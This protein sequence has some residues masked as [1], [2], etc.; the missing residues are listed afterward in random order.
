MLIKLKIK[1]SWLF[2]NLV[3]F[4]SSLP[5][6]F[7]MFHLSFLTLIKIIWNLWNGCGFGCRCQ[8]S[9]SFRLINNIINYELSFIGLHT[10]WSNIRLTLSPWVSYISSYVQYL[11]EFEITHIYF[12]V[13]NVGFKLCLLPN[14]TIP[15]VE[16]CLHQIASSCQHS[17]SLKQMKQTHTLSLAHDEDTVTPKM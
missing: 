7:L 11:W 13:F 9:P 1:N 12:I 10:M 4:S 15:N 17:S 2:F 5:R 3:F 14:R 6:S 16:M 8:L